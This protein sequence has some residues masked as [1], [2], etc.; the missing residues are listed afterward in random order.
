MLQERTFVIAI[1]VGVAVIISTISL[2]SL[3]LN[4]E[5]DDWWSYETMR[6]KMIEAKSSKV[7]EIEESMKF[8]SGKDGT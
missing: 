3:P 4:S 6:N 2:V 7:I 5:Q 8:Q 1:I